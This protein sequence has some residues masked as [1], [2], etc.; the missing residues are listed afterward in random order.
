MKLVKSMKLTRVTG[1]IICIGALLLLGILITGCVTVPKERPSEAAVPE[2]PEEIEREVIPAAPPGP[3]TH[4]IAITEK[5]FQP[6]SF[7]LKAGDTVV[8]TN[9][10]AEAARII[11][12]QECTAINSP[13][14]QPGESFQ[15][16]FETA[17]AC[18]IIIGSGTSGEACND[19]NAC[20]YGRK[21]INSKCFFVSDLYD[22]SLSCIVKCNMNRVKLTT[23]HQ[24]YPERV[25]QKYIL[26]RGR[27][28]SYAGAGALEWQVLDGPDYCQ[29]PEKEVIVP[30][31]V[32][33]K[34]QSKEIG[35]FVIA[36]KPGG[37]S[38]P[39]E[40]PYAELYGFTL[41]VD[42]VHQTCGRGITQ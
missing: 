5:G 42:D 30:I 38:S 10:R 20:G 17:I 31:E 18:P 14:L 19:N 8:W 13:L 11:G 12:G 16:T 23:F 40:H 1:G 27:L 37:Q 2:A 34:Y 32:K 36:L 7:R 39:L 22:T 15:W 26:P 9:R 4:D 28:G 6:A 35:S 41:Q 29:A 25:E 3:A 21:C 24:D 33:Q